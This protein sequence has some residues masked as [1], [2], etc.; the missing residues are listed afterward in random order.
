MSDN[1]ILSGIISKYSSETKK[2]KGRN[3]WNHII[4]MLIIVEVDNWNKGIIIITILSICVFKILHNE[5]FGKKNFMAWKTLNSNVS[6]DINSNLL[7][8]VN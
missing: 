8:S 7:D 4:N 1:N 5:K 3:R 6:N 2:L